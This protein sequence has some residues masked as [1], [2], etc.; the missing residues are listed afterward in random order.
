M[1]FLFVFENRDLRSENRDHVFFR[2]LMKPSRKGDTYALCT[3]CRNDFSIAHGGS[4]D[5]T[6][7]IKTA[8]HLSFGKATE[9][10]RPITHIF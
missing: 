4:N 10:S 7:H 3:L 6:K 1:M 2:G 8:K 5:I 9:S